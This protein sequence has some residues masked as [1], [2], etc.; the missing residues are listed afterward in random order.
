LKPYSPSQSNPWNAEQINLLARRLGFGCSLSDI[1][2]Y[3]NSTPGAMIDDIVGG[4][5]DMEVTPGSRVGS[6]GQ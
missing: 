6:M 5:S 4:A 1:N 3:L 2:L